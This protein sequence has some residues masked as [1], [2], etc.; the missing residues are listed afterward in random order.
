MEIA[1]RQLESASVTLVDGLHFVGE[2][3]DVRIDLDA[4]ESVGGVG[5]GTVN[6]DRANNWLVQWGPRDA[7]RL[8]M[9]EQPHWVAPA[10]DQPGS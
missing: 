3:G 4:E 9:R 5:A 2:I 6:Q 10:L 8:L 7:R 1:K